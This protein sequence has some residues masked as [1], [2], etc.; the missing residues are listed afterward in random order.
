MSVARR[1]AVIAQKRD[2]GAG[3]AVIEQ[4]ATTGWGA[5]RRQ[6]CQSAVPRDTIAKGYALRADCGYTVVLRLTSSTELVRRLAD[7]LTSLLLFPHSARHDATIDR[8]TF[9]FFMLSVT[10]L[11]WCVTR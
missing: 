7:G 8:M 9:F 4:N 1:V 6:P 11:K 5:G 2:Y 3:V 10:Q